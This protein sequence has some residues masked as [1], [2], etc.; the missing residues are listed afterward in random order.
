ML[1]RVHLGGIQGAIQPPP[2]L[3]STLLNLQRQT[4][5]TALKPIFLD[6]HHL[7]PKAW[8]ALSTLWGLTRANVRCSNGPFQSA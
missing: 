6:L 2:I 3:D 1:M 8:V 5:L 4:V 7:R